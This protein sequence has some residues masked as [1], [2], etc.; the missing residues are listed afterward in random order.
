MVTSEAYEPEDILACDFRARPRGAPTVFDVLPTVQHVDRT[1][2]TLTVTFAPA[3]VETV[4]AYVDAERLCCADI[5]W[6]LERRPAL[7]LHISARPG[8]LDI[9]EQLFTAQ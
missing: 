5:R 6:E 4:S 8:Q 1:A 7:R 9:L 3:A 2:A